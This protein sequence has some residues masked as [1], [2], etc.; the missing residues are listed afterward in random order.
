VSDRIAIT[1]YRVTQ[2]A[3]TN[4]SRYAQASNVEVTLR[5]T[6]GQLTLSVVDD[7]QGFE[8]EKLSEREELGIAGMR[9]RASLAGGT[10][11]IRSQPGQ[12][13]GVYLRLP[14]EHK[15]GEKS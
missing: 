12:G 3:L 11:D 14:L 5:A 15:N 4:V 9:E 13:A 2:E 1:A 10:L 8:V 7:G 6:D